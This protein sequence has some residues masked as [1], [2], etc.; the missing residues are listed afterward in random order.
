MENKIREFSKGTRRKQN[1][2]YSKMI[3]SGD[4]FDKK[5]NSRMTNDPNYRRLVYVRYGDDFLIGAISSKKEC[6]LLRN[7]I[8]EFL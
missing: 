6:L 7:Q 5:I 2:A 8:K 4:A 3:K 1:P